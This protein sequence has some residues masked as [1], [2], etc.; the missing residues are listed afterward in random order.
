MTYRQVFYNSYKEHLRIGEIA[1]FDD[2]I[3]CNIQFVFFMVYLCPRI[4]IDL[5]FGT[6]TKIL[7]QVLAFSSRIQISCIQLLYIFGWYQTKNVSQTPMERQWQL[8]KTG[9]KD[10]CSLKL[11]S[12]TGKRT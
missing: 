6:V 7:L 11:K 4:T 1:K 2:K 12:Y 8:R 10:V 9:N 5:F 3:W